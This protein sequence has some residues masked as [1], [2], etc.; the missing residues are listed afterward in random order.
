VLICKSIIDKSNE[1]PA[2]DHVFAERGERGENG[3]DDDDDVKRDC[4]VMGEPKKPIRNTNK[5]PFPE[6]TRREKKKLRCKGET[7]KP[8]PTSR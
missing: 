4:D 7:R 8:E 5:N 2:E 1:I 6:Q 3:D